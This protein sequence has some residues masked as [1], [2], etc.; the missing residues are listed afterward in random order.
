MARDADVGGGDHFINLH[1][2]FT[3]PYLGERVFFMDTTIYKGLLS[4]SSF[5]PDNDSHQNQQDR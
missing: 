2:S 4:L 3:T 1:L 5:I